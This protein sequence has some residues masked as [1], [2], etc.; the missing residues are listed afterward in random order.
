MEER[1]THHPGGRLGG[2]Y[3]GPA[4]GVVGSAIFT[5]VAMLLRLTVDVDQSGWEGESA[6]A[7]FRLA[8]GSPLAVQRG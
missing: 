5:K 7:E 3:E 6:G 1:Q 4:S 8:S 2:A